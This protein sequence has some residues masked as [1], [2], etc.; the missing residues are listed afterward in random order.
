MRRN[1]SLNYI[2]IIIIIIK[3]VLI[4]SLNGQV[5]SQVSRAFQIL[6]RRFLP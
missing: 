6:D 2:I 5:Q 4:K 3:N 1:T